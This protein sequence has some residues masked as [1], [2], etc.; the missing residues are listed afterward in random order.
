MSQEGNVLA[1]QDYLTFKWNLTESQCP[2]VNTVFI[3]V[4]ALWIWF[5][6]V[7]WKQ[8][9]LWRTVYCVGTCIECGKILV[10][11][12]FVRIL[13]LMLLFLHFVLSCIILW[14]VSRSLFLLL[15]LPVCHVSS[16]H[17]YFSLLFWLIPLQIQLLSL[18]IRSNWWP[19][20]MCFQ[21]LSSFGASIICGNSGRIA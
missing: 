4:L 19:S 21:N 11:Q 1:D 20:S 7:I 5:S 17:F 13:G 6:Y 15:L 2:I 9:S 18:Q 8:A 14:C 12:L 10:T 3:E 16:T